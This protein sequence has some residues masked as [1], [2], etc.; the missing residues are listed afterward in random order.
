MT[1]MVSALSLAADP[2]VSGFQ[3]LQERTTVRIEKAESLIV[4][5][6]KSLSGF[7]TCGLVRWTHQR[8]SVDEG[9]PAEA[10]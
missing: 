4:T 3:S 9:R 1:F 8:A 2:L 10:S 7:D 6:R 5:H